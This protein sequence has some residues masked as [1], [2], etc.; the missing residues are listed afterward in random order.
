[1]K[2]VF[3]GNVKKTKELVKS[4]AENEAIFFHQFAKSMVKM[5]NI[6]NPMTKLK[7]EI[8]KNCRRVN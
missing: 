8:R 7:V 3:T 4:Y 2:C 6:I 5:G 1:M